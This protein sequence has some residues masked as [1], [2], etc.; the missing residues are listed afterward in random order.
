MAVKHTSVSYIGMNSARRAQE[1]F[2]EIREHGCDTVIL[3]ITEFDVD[4]YLPSLNDIVKAAHDT[5]L[6]AIADP[7]G[8]GKFFGGE[9]VSLFLQNNVHHRQVSALTGETLNAACFNTN[10]FRDYFMDLCMKIARNTDVDGFFW[11]EPHY[12]LPKSY[13]SLTGSAGEDWACRCPEC[14]EKFRAYYGYEMPRLLTDDVAHFRR[15]E[16]LKILADTSKALKAYKPSLEITCCVH[17]TLNS[18]YV[19]EN[20]GYDDWDMVASCPYFDVFSTTILRWDLPE[21]FF[22]EIG[23]RTVAAA[24]R[25]GKQSERWIQGYFNQP[26]DFAQIDRTVDLYDSLGVDRLATWTFR[27]CEGTTVAAPDP[28]ALWDRIGQNFARVLK[29]EG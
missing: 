10:A 12:A 5:G 13:A 1:D 22:R 24:Q 19:T 23:E 9:Q 15:R 28:I 7:W 21:K 27:G 26:Q 6:R 4:F 16:A 20:R 17:A 29:K 2:R 3:A 8:I 25:Y 14:M 18:Y 11:D